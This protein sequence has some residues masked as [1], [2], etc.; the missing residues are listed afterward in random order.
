MK[1]NKIAVATTAVFLSG[2]AQAFDARTIAQGGAGVAVGDYTQHILNPAHLASFD[3]DDD[4]GVNLGIGVLLQDKDDLV[5][6]ADKAADAVNALADT[7]GN[8]QAKAQL[9]L[10]SLDNLANKYLSV[11]AGGNGFI[12]IPNSVMPTSLYVSSAL[13]MSAGVGEISAG[14]RG[15]IQDA[16]NNGNSSAV[17]IDDLETQ[18]EASAVMTVDVGI[19]VANEVDTAL[20][21]KLNIGGVLKYQQVTL[22]DYSEAVAAFDDDALLDTES[23]HSNF[24]IDLGAAYQLNNTLSFGLTA[25][26]LIGKTY[27]SKNS[28]SEYKVKPEL[29]A[30]VGV[31]HGI[32]SV[33][34]DLQLTSTGGYGAVQESRYASLGVTLDFWEHARLSAGYRTDLEDNSADVLTAGVG[35]SPWDIFG[36]NAAVMVGED[37]TYGAALQFSAKF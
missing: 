6:T 17:T 11:E 22:I 27:K 16:I 1:L 5:D 2:A 37:K 28:T 4:F 8:Y 34:G 21:G 24:N 10:D 18:V 14:D 33:M 19:A 35:L 3:Q 23:S 20:P 25:K 13:N 26:N 9:A 31:E 12:A 32:V 29:T 7:T 36:L 30:G 15:E